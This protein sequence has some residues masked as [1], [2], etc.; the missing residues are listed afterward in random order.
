MF[1]G[2]KILLTTYSTA[3]ITS[4]GG[5][6]EIVRTAE[7]LRAFGAQVDI[8]G[9][10]SRPLKFYDFVIH[11][12]IHKSGAELFSSVKDS[13]K[14]I[15]LFPNVWW[16]EQPS[17][18]EVERVKSFL[19]KADK[20]I[21]KSRAEF[22]NFSKYIS[23]APDNIVIMSLP[24]S[25][26][27][28][29]EVDEKLATAYT[30][31]EKY[32]LCIGLLEPI[33]NQL[34]V[35]RA[36]NSI[37]MGGVFIGGVRD[38]VYAEQC[39]LEA[40][41]R[42]KFLPF[43]APASSLLRS[44]IKGSSVIL[45]PSFDPPGRSVLEGAFLK[46]PVVISKSEWQEEYFSNNCFAVSPDSYKDIAKGVLAALNGAEMEIKVN[47]AFKIFMDNNLDHLVA[48]KFVHSIFNINDK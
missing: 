34:N 14:K 27:F 1:F 46:R 11:F 8:Y 31:T 18:I 43:I 6:V 44:I 45:E 24:I 25:T 36:L 38:E 22:D 5:E 2:L 16:L 19:S 37:S 48:E 7:M 10:S 47:N 35:I 13:G 23:L 30:G 21:F 41:P 42:I 17:L 15:F 40:N 28:L 9:P 33:K 20:V 12:S 39:R 32:A 4:G 3:Y 29:D 26:S